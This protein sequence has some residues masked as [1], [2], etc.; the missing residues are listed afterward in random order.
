MNKEKKYADDLEHCRKSIVKTKNLI[1]YHRDMLKKLEKKETALSDKLEKVKVN[2]L[3]EMLHKGGYDIDTVRLAVHNG[4]FSSVT[5]QKNGSV[6]SNMTELEN[7]E[8][9]PA[10][11]EQ[12]VKIE[13]DER[14]NEL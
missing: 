13:I 11:K 10:T 2:S 3:F 7:E 8:N 1:A 14:K 5:A 4:D 12:T 6:T 9:L